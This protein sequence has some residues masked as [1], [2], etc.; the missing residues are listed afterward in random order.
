MTLKET[1]E[2]ML[3]IAQITDNIR[4]DTDLTEAEQQELITDILK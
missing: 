2:L 4:A 3:E 1:L